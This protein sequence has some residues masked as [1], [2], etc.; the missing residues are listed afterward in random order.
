MQKLIDIFRV[1]Q[2]AYALF[3][4]ICYILVSCIVALNT[5]SRINSNQTPGVREKELEKYGWLIDC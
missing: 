4:P 2:G 1:V 3:K 5:C